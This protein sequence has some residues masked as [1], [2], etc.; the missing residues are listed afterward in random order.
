MA[1]FM[2]VM[3]VFLFSAFSVSSSKSITGSRETGLVGEG[4]FLSIMD[5]VLLGTN[6]MSGR[7]LRNDGET[8]T[9]LKNESTSAVDGI[10]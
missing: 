1:C 9:M 7:F 3:T 2:G 6:V 8:N 10:N 4:F 5:I